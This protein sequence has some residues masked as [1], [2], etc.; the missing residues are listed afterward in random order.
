MKSL[1]F[2]MVVGVLSATGAVAPQ[3]ASAQSL[4]C[5]I[6]PPD[7][8]GSGTPLPTCNASPSPALN[9]D[10]H[11]TITGLGSGPYS[12][13]WSQ[14]HVAHGP[15]PPLNGGIPCTTAV[16]DQELDSNSTSGDAVTVQ[17][18]VTNTVTH[19]VLGPFS[20]T[21]RIPCVTFK[22]NQHPTV[23]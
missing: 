21:A 17:V 23:C 4:V 13:S 9:Y 5:T 10:A 8:I 2:G 1:L 7:P 12:Y 16:C 22:T 15:Q 6:N 14:T 18:V 19:G 20:A 3:V 11:F